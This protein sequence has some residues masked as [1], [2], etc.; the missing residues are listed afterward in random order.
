MSAMK[1]RNRRPMQHI[2]RHDLHTNLETRIK[3]LH[4]FLDFSSPVFIPDTP[5]I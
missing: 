1:L 5:L 4:F 2:D 3:Y